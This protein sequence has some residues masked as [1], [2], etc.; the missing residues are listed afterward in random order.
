MASYLLRVKTRL[1]KG[2]VAD[3][4]FQETIYFSSGRGLEA[5]A[6][7]LLTCAEED[8]KKDAMRS[9]SPACGASHRRG[10]I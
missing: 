3:E 4:K 2:D 6:F 5:R 10:P 8:I 1:G 7:A 9:L